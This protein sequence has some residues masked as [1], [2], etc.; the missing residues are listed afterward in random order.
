MRLSYPSIVALYVQDGSLS[1]SGEPAENW[2]DCF[3]F[4]ENDALQNAIMTCGKRRVD[5]ECNSAV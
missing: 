5:E 4:Y 2:N 3:L 1:K